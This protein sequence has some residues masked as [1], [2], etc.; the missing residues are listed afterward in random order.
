VHFVKRDFKSTVPATTNG[1]E[2]A[3]AVFLPLPCGMNIYRIQNLQPLSQHGLILFEVLCGP[4]FCKFTKCFSDCNI[5]FWN[6]L[7]VLHPWHTKNVSK[8]GSLSKNA[9]SL[10]RPAPWKPLAGFRNRFLCEWWQTR[11][12][13]L[14]RPLNTIL[15]KS[16]RRCPAEATDCHRIITSRNLSLLPFQ[17]HA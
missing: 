2:I 12:Q 15:G 10:C 3:N 14:R 4:H 1:P 5:A 7:Q 13:T 11:T 8:L 16:F 17:S 6:V 9:Y